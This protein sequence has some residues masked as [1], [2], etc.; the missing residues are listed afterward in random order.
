M[1]VLE[2]LLERVRISF[3]EAY[4]IA[5]AI[6]DG[7]FDE[8]IIAAL[9]VALRAHGETPDIIAGFAKALREASL[10]VNTRGLSPIDTAGTGGDGFHT[11]NASTAAAL[12]TASL[13]V[14]T[15]KHG[16]RSV[17]SR[18]G[19][20]DFLEALGYKID[21][22]PHE[23]EFMLRKVGFAFLYAPRYH[24]AL[25]RVMPIRRKLGIRTIFNLIGPLA[26]PGSIRI[27][28]LGVASPKLLE[29]M[30]TAALMLNYD[31][32]LVV[33]GKPG[34]DEVSIS[35]ETE[36]FELRRKSLDRY[37]ISPEDL[38]LRRYRIE[39]LRVSSPNESAKRFL[40]VINGHGSPADRDFIAANAGAALYVA[41][42]ASDIR[43]GVEMALQAIEEGIVAKFID[44]LCEVSKYAGLR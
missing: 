1:N 8:T 33:H 36:V 35:G 37:T 12:V 5:R 6:I 41:E 21:H 9:L 13:G 2:K 26:N 31:R 42:R 34:I 18:S 38:G 39:D 32:V 16:N 30:T 3:L 27:Q 22:G 24:P 14:P 40:A 25:K 17:S 4:Q 20:A 10:K 7:K 15:L 19:S 44:T 28:V 29:V 43:D 11:I 23:A